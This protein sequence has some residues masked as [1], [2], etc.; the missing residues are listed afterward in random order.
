MRL[1][2]KFLGSAAGLN[3]HG[4]TI[5]M[6]LIGGTVHQVTLRIAQHH[7]PGREPFFHLGIINYGHTTTR[8]TL[9]TVLATYLPTLCCQGLSM[10]N[11][12]YICNQRICTISSLLE[13]RMKLHAKLTP[14]TGSCVIYPEARI[15]PLAAV[16]RDVGP[17]SVRKVLLKAV[18][19]GLNPENPHS[20]WAVN[21]P[22]YSQELRP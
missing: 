7:P 12:E 11:T 16:M 4:F 8:C 17:S 2:R 20:L 19:W 13:K 3:R 10:C 6:V 14:R 1:S 18:V 15:D 21:A 22:P 9:C 5:L